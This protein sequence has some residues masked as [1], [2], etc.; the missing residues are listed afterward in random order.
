MDIPLLHGK[1]VASLVLGMTCVSLYPV[2]GNVML[3][4]EGQ[5]LLPQ[6]NIECGLLIGLYPALLLPA[7]HPALCYAVHHILAVGGEYYLTGLF[8][9]GKACYNAEKLHS[10]VGGGAVAPRKLLFYA[11][12]AEHYPVASG[13]GIAAAGA[14]CKYFNC[15]DVP[16]LLS[17]L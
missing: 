16:H 3:F 6:V 10:V 8:Q 15:F 14:V 1:S 17:P 5:K 9:R 13:T 11:A 7:V 12:E 2:E 4:K